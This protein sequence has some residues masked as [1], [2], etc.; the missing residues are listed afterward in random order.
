MERVQFQFDQIE[1]S[2]IERASD[3]S[4]IAIDRPDTG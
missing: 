1:L 2:G 4:I 3:N